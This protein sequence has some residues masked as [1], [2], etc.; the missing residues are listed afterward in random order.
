MLRK[1]IR[2][3]YTLGDEAHAKGEHDK[4]SDYY[5]NTIRLIEQEH[6]FHGKFSTE[7]KEL[8]SEIYIKR[9]N[10][11]I[12]QKNYS[13]AIHDCHEAQRVGKG[14]GINR[15]V[16][17][18]LILG[19]AFSKIS[20]RDHV[21]HI[22]NYNYLSFPGRYYGALSGYV[23]ALEINPNCTEAQIQLER[24]LSGLKNCE[25]DYRELSHISKLDLVNAISK[26]NRKAQISLY[27][28]CLKK[29]TPLGKRI[30][31][32]EF[33]WTG[34]SLERGT[35]KIIRDRLDHLYKLNEMTELTCKTLKSVKKG[36]WMITSTTA[37]QDSF[38][39]AV[40]LLQ[41]PQLV[42]SGVF[43][44]DIFFHITS[45]ALEHVFN[46][47]KRYYL[48]AHNSFFYNAA[49]HSNSTHIQEEKY[50]ENTQ[51]VLRPDE[52]DLNLAILKKKF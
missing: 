12:K 3:N 23:A 19:N 52:Q 6:D 36:K 11:R 27:E 8:W 14:L 44:A 18:H 37:R 40:W 49:L 9:A 51:I 41:A 25:M 30:W 39:M 28:E 15:S 45:Y 48:N 29:N 24:F 32:T 47:V 31:T 50:R 22:N 46:T 42:H 43:N 26:L 5:T 17:L 35:L 34:C 1:M 13:E 21:W 10:V 2:N 20:H 4:A 33:P 7:V 38:S 16:E